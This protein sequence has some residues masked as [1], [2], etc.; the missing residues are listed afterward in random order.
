MVLDGDRA[1][2]RKLRIFRVTVRTP[3]KEPVDLRF[4]QPE[5]RIGS[6]PSNDVVLVD[7]AVSR[8]HVEIK[9]DALGFRLRDLGSTNGTFVGGVRV[10]DGYLS[11][12][13]RIVVGRTQIIFS[14]LPE[15][16]DLPLYPADRFGPLVGRSSAMRALFATIE[17]A[18]NSEATMLLH[19]ESGTGKELVAE[20]I[21]QAS[22]RRR[23]P[24]VVFDCSAV[25]PNLIES[26]LFGHEKGA[27]T[28]AEQ[29]RRG[30]LEEAAGGTVFMDEIGELPLELQPKLLRVLESRRIRAVGSN[31]TV[32]LDVRFVAAT[33]RDLAQ[34]VN[35]GSFREDLYYRLAVV[36]VTIPPLRE[37]KEDIPLLV[38]HL[39]GQIF[40]G[41]P[42]RAKSMLRAMRPEQWQKL[43]GHSWRG[44]VRELR[45]TVERAVAL[46]RGEDIS[47]EPQSLGVHPATPI[48]ASGKPPVDLERP[49]KEQK[50]A[51]IEAFERA[52]LLGILEAHD[53][54]I[55]RAAQAANLERMY[56]KRL[57][58]RYR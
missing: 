32:P 42:E 40:A 35:Q 14:P 28:G 24:F 4:E 54:N 15:N 22:P 10:N 52:Y 7:E 29:R 2:A 27:F 46:S 50:K 55:S 51:L 37:R 23:G 45:N 49:F 13:A 20:A 33:H 11:P 19:G 5:I 17:R 48:A 8:L 39:T 53:G 41:Q 16:V 3:E 18:A 36:R 38:E 6:H 47:L 25:S 1:V 9:S 57:L 58:S 44:N 21:H 31:R 56:F 12:G 43:A 30:V 26:E 34:E